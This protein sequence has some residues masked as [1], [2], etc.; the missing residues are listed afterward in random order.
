MSSSASSQGLTNHAM[1]QL[2][3]YSNCFDDVRNARRRSTLM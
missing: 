1:H 2:R 3:D